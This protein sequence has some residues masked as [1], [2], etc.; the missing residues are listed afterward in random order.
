MKL[1]SAKAEHPHLWFERA[2]NFFAV[3]MDNL[4]EVLP[5]PA[6]RP[7]PAADPALT[8]L[9]ALRD[10]VLPVFDPLIL[11]GC[12]TG[13]SAPAGS[14]VIVLKGDRHHGLALLAEK[15]G[16]I[17]ELTSLDPLAAGARVPIAFAGES[18]LTDQRRLLIVEVASLAQVMGLHECDAADAS[19]TATAQ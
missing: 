14:I 8:G 11:A 2:G 4:Q 19:A 17:V 15:V 12:S 5:V 18:R 9:I 16:K 10:R 13:P 6:L 1:T 7:L 3:P